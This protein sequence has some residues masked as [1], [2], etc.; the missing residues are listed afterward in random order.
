MTVD[1]LRRARPS[2]P[3]PSF[4]VLAV[5][6]AGPILTHEAVFGSRVGL[7]AA[8]AG[9]VV[10]LLIAAA[11]TRWSW[12]TL[13]TLAAV[14]LGYFLVGGPVALPSTVRWGVATTDT[15]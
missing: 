8:G 10:G 15:L 12:D 2:L 11:S 9:V 13:S 3:L 4:L 6:F 1:D 14:L 7:T 5:L